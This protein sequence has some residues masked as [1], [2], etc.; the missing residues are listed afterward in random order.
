[1]FLPDLQYR[2]RFFL[3]FWVSTPPHV[4]TQP[5]LANWSAVVNRPR[6]PLPR[7]CGIPHI[8]PRGPSTPRR[9]RGRAL[10]RYASLY[11]RGWFG[12]FR[13]SSL[14]TALLEK[15]MRTKSSPRAEPTCVCCV[16]EH[17]RLNS[18]RV[19]ACGRSAMLNQDNPLVHYGM[20]RTRMRAR[21]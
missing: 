12:L 16:H 10:G 21:A 17:L 14:V 18:F 19:L 5:S 8:K 3:F 15:S 4:S 2:I 9:R 7:V 1:M 20:Q 11:C 13:A 6:K